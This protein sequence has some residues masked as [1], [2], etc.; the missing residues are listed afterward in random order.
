MT[1]ITKITSLLLLVVLCVGMLAS[2]GLSSY[3]KRLTDAGYTVE[4]I[5]DEDI[6]K[7][8]DE[9]DEYKIKASIIATKDF[10][11]VTIIQFANASQAKDY[12]ESLEDSQKIANAVI[13]TVKYEVKGS[14]V[15]A[16]TIKSVDI[17][18]GK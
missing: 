2:C 16:G 18:L 14:V 17:A 5:S 3:E 15:I 10:N 4:A 12:A 7:A 8:N 1:K 6:K 11:V 13:E 9:N